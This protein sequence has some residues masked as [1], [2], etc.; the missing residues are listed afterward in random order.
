M[1]NVTAGPGGDLFIADAG[2]IAVIRRDAATGT[3]SVFATLPT[4]PNPAPNAPPVEA[5]PTG[6]VFNGRT[7]LVSTFTGFPFPAGQATLYEIDQRGKVS[8]YQRGFSSL[9]DLELGINRKP[10]VVEYGKWT[11]ETFEPNSGQVTL[12]GNGKTTP[13]LTGLNFPNSIERSGVKTYYLAQTFDGVILK[14]SQ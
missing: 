2:A 14:V 3:L 1:F 10:V 7:F 9:A 5:V 6:I 12:V 13:L 11:G 8:V 4:I